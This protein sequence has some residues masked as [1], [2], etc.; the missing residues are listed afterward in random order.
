MQG[1]RRERGVGGGSDDGD[2]NGSG[3]GKKEKKSFW[4]RGKGIPFASYLS[5]C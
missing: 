3:E 2:N 5:E 4:R 1:G